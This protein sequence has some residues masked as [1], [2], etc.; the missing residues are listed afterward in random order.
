VTFVTQLLD[1]LILRLRAVTGPILIDKFR[2]G[3]KA[4][5]RLPNGPR[6]CIDPGLGATWRSGYAT[7]CKAM[8]FAE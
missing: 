7:V 1:H 6:L 2:L 3:R 5:E 4:R 8:S